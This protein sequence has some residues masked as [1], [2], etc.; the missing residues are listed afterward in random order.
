MFHGYI[1]LELAEE[2]IFIANQYHDLIYTLFLIITAIILGENIVI[3][4]YFVVKYTEA[5]SWQRE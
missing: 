5:K 4:R 1:H 2:I 3:F